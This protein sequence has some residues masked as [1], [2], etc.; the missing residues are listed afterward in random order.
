[1]VYSVV[2]STAFR[3]SSLFILFGHEIIYLQGVLTAT[4]NRLIFFAAFIA[5]ELL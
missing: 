2:R 1:M 5:N 4:L 3:G